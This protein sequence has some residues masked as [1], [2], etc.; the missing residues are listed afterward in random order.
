MNELPIKTHARTEMIDITISIED[1]VKSIDAQSGVCTIYCPHTTAG[2]MINECA[3]P[4]VANDILA[5]LN[6]L[7]PPDEGYLHIEGNSDAHIKT[8]LVGN[9]IQVIVENGHLCMGTWQGIFF[10]EFDGPRN[11]RVWIAIS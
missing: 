11:R 1:I 8:A 9:S 7:V 10:C 5:K 4:D 6:R 3:D 2:V